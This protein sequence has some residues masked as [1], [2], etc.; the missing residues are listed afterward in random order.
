M[1]KILT[2]VVA[3]LFSF[4][5]MGQDRFDDARVFRVGADVS[6]DCFLPFAVGSPFHSSAG[7]G[8][9]ARYGRPDQWVNLIGGVRYIYGQ[10]LS[11]IQIPVMMNV[12]LLRLDRVS[13]YLGGG[14]EFDFIGTYW[15]CAKFQGGFLIGPH[16]D[17]RVFYKP[18][19][20]DLGLGFTYYF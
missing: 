16:T 9:R 19:Q 4:A 18:Y 8:V 17:L 5:L 15:G 6:A 3:C 20:A 11:G 10:R 14:Y 12:N 13:A 2:F 1:K 7:V